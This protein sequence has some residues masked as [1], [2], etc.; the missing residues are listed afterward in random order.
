MDEYQS[1]M[2]NNV[3]DIVMRLEGKSMVKSKWIYNIMHA[4]H[5][6][7]E[8]HKARFLKIGLSYKEGVNYEDTFGPVS[9]YT[10]LKTIIALASVM[11][12]ILH[13]INVNTTFLNGVIEEEACIEKPKGFVMHVEESHVCILK[14]ALYKLK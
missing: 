2:K 4:I 5:G 11:G 12:W 13:Q 14:N 7:I 1:I 6:N 8:K 10:S 3:W 9:R